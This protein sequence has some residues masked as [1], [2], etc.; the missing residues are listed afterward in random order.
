MADQ[1]RSVLVI[2]TDKIG[3][4]ILSTP[5]IASVR[6]ACPSSRLVVLASPYNRP[7]FDDWRAIDEVVSYDRTWPAR[8]RQETVR[9]LRHEQFDLSLVLHPGLDAYLAAWR[10]G[11]RRRV[12]LVHARQL[13]DRAGASLLLT[14]HV[15]AHVEAAAASGAPVPHEV[16]LTRSVLERARLPWAGD[17]L[18]APP[19]SPEAQA[20]VSHL[21]SACGSGTRAVVG[22]H[23]A[24]KWL[25][26]GW[27]ADDV[28]QLLESLAAAPGTMV[29]GTV[30]PSDSQ[31]ADLIG[32]APVFELLTDGPGREAWRSRGARVVI[33]RVDYA[34]WGAVFARCAVVVTPDTGA[35]H[36]ASALGRP[37]V[38]VY[39][40]E[41]ARVNMQQFA[42]W[43][44]PSRCLLHRRP[45]VLT[46][47]IIG[48]VGALAR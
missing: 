2:R 43:R 30:G 35:V 26:H 8:R 42:P 44:V 7:V 34:L 22:V 41:R 5:A 3:D 15:V 23:L 12:G 38:A 46:P 37:V 27:Q 28:V 4:A 20:T 47:E 31:A 32:R 45:A 17:L 40:P 25:G 39:A 24:D 16:E 10:T 1:P 6:S 36:L 14:D 11:A 13:W 9:G 19:L 33:T 18:A 48:A 21:S 29:I